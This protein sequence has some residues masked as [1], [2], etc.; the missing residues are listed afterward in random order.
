M[1]V[2][3]Y[4]DAYLYA[5]VVVTLHVDV[6]IRRC[7]CT[8]MYLCVCDCVHT[9][10]RVPMIHE[11]ENAA[12]ESTCLASSSLS[13]SLPLWPCRDCCNHCNCGPTNLCCSCLSVCCDVASVVVRVTAAPFSVV[14]ITVHVDAGLSVPVLFVSVRLASRIAASL[15]SVVAVVVFVAVAAAALRV[16]SCA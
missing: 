7:I 16:P 5:L 4:M 1:Y 13:L 11:P 14:V 9:N 10:E 3:A 6:V 15:V 2:C 12:V 8:S